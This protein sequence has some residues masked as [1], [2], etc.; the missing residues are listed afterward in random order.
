M[1][2]AHNHSY[3]LPDKNDIID[4]ENLK[5]IATEVKKLLLFRTKFPAASSVVLVTTL[6]ARIV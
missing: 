1:H 5:L 6:A 3:A 4:I 2:Y